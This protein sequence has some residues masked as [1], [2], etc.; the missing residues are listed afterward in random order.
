MDEQKVLRNEH[1]RKRDDRLFL[2]MSVVRSMAFM[3]VIIGTIFLC[4]WIAGLIV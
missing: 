4:E 3:A 1:Q 2:F